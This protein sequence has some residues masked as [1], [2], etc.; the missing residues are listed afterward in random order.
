M[1]KLSNLYLL[2]YNSLQAVAW[3]VCLALSLSS[4]VSTKAVNGAYAS[5]GDLIYFLQMVQFLE[6]I[7]GAVGL[8]PSGVV[9]PLMQWAG[10]A[11]FLFVLRQTH[12]V[13]E[14]PSVF[15]T[16]VAW[17]L[18]EVIRYPHYA[19]NC[20]GS[21]PSWITYLRY[22]AFIVLYPPG[23]AG[24]TWLMY[25]ALPFVKKR[26]LFPDLFAGLSYYNFLRVLLVCYP[27]LCLK[28][29]LH[30][31]KQRRSKLGKHPKKKKR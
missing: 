2:A 22:T 25:Q 14:S 31:F 1:P 26:S 7:H 23:M 15:I 30:M 21:C 27:F 12:E 28:L 16:F 11:H 10:R 6:V 3:A 13:Q 20:M 19:F 8:V 17:S 4:F 9:F 18:S 24:E 29:Y 5:A